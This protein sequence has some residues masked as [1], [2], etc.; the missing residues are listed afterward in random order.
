MSNVKNIRFLSGENCIGEIVSEQGGTVTLKDVIVAMPINEEGTQLGFAPWAP[1]QDPDCEE[2]EI[3]RD[4]ILY[5]TNAAPN[6][7]EQYTKMF[8][9]TPAVVVPEKKLIL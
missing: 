8:N 3:Q 5:I 7:V 2:L 4:H 9:K 1:L 6:L